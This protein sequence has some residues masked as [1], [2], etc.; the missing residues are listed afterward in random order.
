[1]TN[2]DSSQNLGYSQDPYA[3]PG[4]RIEDSTPRTSRSRALLAGAI[5]AVVIGVLIGLAL[6]SERPVQF[7]WT[8]DLS[9]FAAIVVVSGACFL[10]FPRMKWPWVIFLAPFVTLALV[11]IVAF[12]LIRFVG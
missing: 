8:R 5:S 12:A 4:G 10:P 7:E 9:T 1:V 6:N 3:P 11:S 2:P